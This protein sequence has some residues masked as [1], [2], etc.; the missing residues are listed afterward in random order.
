VR[1][2]LSGEVGFVRRH[3][4]VE[5]RCG[6]MRRLMNNRATFALLSWVVAAAVTPALAMVWG[7]LAPRVSA[8]A[9]GVKPIDDLE[10]YAVYSALLPDEAMR[11][12]RRS[13]IVI[14]AEAITDQR[15]WPSGPPIETEWKSTFESL[16]AENS[17]ARTIRSGFTLSVPYIVLPKA[18]IMAFFTALRPDSWKHFYERYPDSAGFLG[19]SAVGFDTDRTEAIV[20]IAHSYNFLGGEYS[21]HL[22]RKLG[23][24][25]QDTRVPGVNTCQVAS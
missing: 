22:L 13:M 11:G 19:L 7:A 15:C 14:Q 4:V 5:E 9:S 2:H 6:F 10:S 12:M 16:R 21:Y 1:G 8:Q 24:N 20:Y 25:W 3:F 17:H 23:G 18:D